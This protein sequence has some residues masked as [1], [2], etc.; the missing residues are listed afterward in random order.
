VS[1]SLPAASLLIRTFPQMPVDTNRQP[2]MLVYV[3]APSARQLP[4]QQLVRELFG[5]TAAEARLAILLADGSSLLEAAQSMGITESTV[6]TYSKRI[7][8][9]TD[10]APSPM[11]P[12]IGL[13]W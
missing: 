8:G 12:A 5:L 7:L 6:R 11:S 4:P 2:A 13:D 3:T 1:E 10:V 9:K